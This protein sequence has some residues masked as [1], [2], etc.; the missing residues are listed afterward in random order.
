MATEKPTQ[1]RAQPIAGTRPNVRLDQQLADDLALLMKEGSS[2]TDA[3]RDAVHLVAELRR[4]AADDLDVVMRTTDG[5]TTAV[6]DASVMYRT[7]WL[8][9][10]VAVNTAPTLAS[11]K[12]VE[13]PPM[14]GPPSLPWAPSSSLTSTVD[15][16]RQ[17]P[18]TPPR[19]VRR[20]APVG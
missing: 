4:Q 14:P 5:L 15:A 18:P 12:F 8:H 1:R 13:K 3:V 16:R 11:F 20:P 17:A 7:A 10:V 2:L 6:R 9:R 19:A